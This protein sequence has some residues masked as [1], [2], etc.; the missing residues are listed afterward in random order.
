MELDA[1]DGYDVINH[2]IHGLYGDVR[3]DHVELDGA[4]EEDDAKPP[5]E[6][7]NASVSN[8]DVISFLEESRSREA[9]SVTSEPISESSLTAMLSTISAQPQDDGTAAAEAVSLLNMIDGLQLV[10]GS[11]AWKYPDPRLNLLSSQTLSTPDQHV[12]NLIVQLSS[13]TFSFQLLS[14]CL[15]WPVRIYPRDAKPVSDEL[16]ASPKGLLM[17]GS[18]DHCVVAAVNGD[19][20]NSLGYG[21]NF[22]VHEE[23]GDVVIIYCARSLKCREAGE[24]ARGTIKT[25]Q[26]V[27]SAPLGT[28]RQRLAHALLTEVQYRV[29]YDVICKGTLKKRMRTVEEFEEA[30]EAFIAGDDFDIRNELL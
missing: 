7:S 22:H 3:D 28:S 29:W 10:C 26:E 1:G 30:D 11:N 12:S 8:W 13:P 18:R 15:G 6:F 14:S 25:E 24:Y 19:N 17:S 4:F 21:H 27:A 2:E 5:N 20:D 9:S 23:V 16:H